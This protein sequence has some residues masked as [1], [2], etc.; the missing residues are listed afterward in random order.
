[1]WYHYDTPH[2]IPLA[3]LLSHRYAALLVVPGA[4]YISSGVR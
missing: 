3:S 4:K 2:S 1:M